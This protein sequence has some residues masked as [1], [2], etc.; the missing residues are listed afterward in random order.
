MCFKMTL[1]DRNNAQHP[2]S[3]RD[4]QPAWEI[5]KHP[6]CLNHPE[7]LQLLSIPY[8]PLST[9]TECSSL[10]L[11]PRSHS[12]FSFLYILTVYMAYWFDWQFF[13]GQPQKHPRISHPLKP[14]HFSFQESAVHASWAHD[15]STVRQPTA[16]SPFSNMHRSPWLIPQPCFPP[17]ERQFKH[18]PLLM[19]SP[20]Y[21]LSADDMSLLRR[22]NQ[23]WTWN[24]ET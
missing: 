24:Q 2:P 15:G 5:V 8:H 21:E 1:C 13:Q 9:L 3:T 16:N 6:W 19:S 18:C 10:S 12:P 4:P 20:P 14:C 17:P 7:D 22:R 11:T 23:S